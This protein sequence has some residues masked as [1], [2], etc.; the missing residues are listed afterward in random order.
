[1]KQTGHTSLAMVRRYARADQKDRQFA[2]G[3]L[4]L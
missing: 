3:K 4:G 1:M 2:E